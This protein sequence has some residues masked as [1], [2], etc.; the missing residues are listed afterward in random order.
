MTREYY[1]I[2]RQQRSQSARGEWVPYLLILGA[3]TPYFGFQLDIRLE[4]LFAYPAA[5]L[6]VANGRVTATRTMRI[7]RKVLI[8]WLILAALVLISTGLRL[9]AVAESSPAVR[10]LA[11]LDSFLLP[12]ALVLVSGSFA[13]VDPARWQRQMRRATGSVV[14]LISLNSLL[15][16]LFTVDQIDGFVRQFWSNPTTTVAGASVAEMALLG[17]RYGGIFNQPFDGGLAYALALMGWSYLFVLNRRSTP[18]RWVAGLGSL[19]LILAGG[20]STGSKVF[21][22]GSV[23]VVALTLLPDAGA[24]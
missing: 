23:L 14:A 22:Y 10:L 11:I 5:L 8:P 6:L 13:A 9:T 3:F 7:G 21:V 24:M 16:V 12:V 1:A 2:R 19:A 18:H 17:G 4:H 20:V 15:I